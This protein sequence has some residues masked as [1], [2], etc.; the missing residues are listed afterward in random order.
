MLKLEI[1]EIVQLIN[2]SKHFEAECIDSSFYLK[3]DEYTP[4]VCFAIHN[5]HNLRNDIKQ[6]CLLTEHERWQEEDP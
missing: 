6:N 4:F 2:E 3:I 5:G 1:A